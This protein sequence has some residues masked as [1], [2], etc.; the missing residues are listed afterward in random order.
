MMAYLSLYDTDD[1][2]SWNCGEIPEAWKKHN[3]VP[4]HKKGKQ[5]KFGNYGPVNLMFIPGTIMKWLIKGFE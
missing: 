4:V 1:V 5:D 3:V 2:C